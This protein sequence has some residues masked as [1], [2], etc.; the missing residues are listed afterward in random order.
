M[1]R[2]ACESYAVFS[3][4]HVNRPALNNEGLS[5]EAGNMLLHRT[6]GAF[7]LQEPNRPTNTISFKFGWVDLFK[8]KMSPLTS[9]MFLEWRLSSLVATWCSSFLHP[10]L[11][12]TMCV[13]HT[14]VGCGVNL[15]GLVKDWINSL[16][17]SATPPPLPPPLSMPPASHSFKLP[18]TSFSL[19]RCHSETPS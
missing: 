19:S 10:W 1:E 18:C 17:H 4:Q 5:T 6:N 13:W 11:C 15:M 8:L 9:H 16:Y 7:F 2:A 12:G 14:P 3:L